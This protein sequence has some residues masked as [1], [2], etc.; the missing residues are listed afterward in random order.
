MTS[1]LIGSGEQPYI[2]ARR[3]WGAAFAALRRLMAN[4]DDTEQVF[5]IMDAL[6][7]DEEVR[8]FRK[9]TST[10]KGGAIAYRRV[11]LAERLMDRDWLNRFAPDSVGGVYRQFLDATGYSAQGLAEISKVG[12]SQVDAEHPYAW[13]GRRSRDVHDLWHVL[14]GYKADE[15]LGEAALVA[16]SFAQLG[17]WGWGA[18]ALATWFETLSAGWSNAQGKAIRE[19]YRLGKTAAWLMGEDYEQVLGERIVD[20]RRRLNIGTPE[21]YLAIPPE[22]RAASLGRQPAADRQV[23][24]LHGA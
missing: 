21:A 13:M 7:A 3:D 11:E 12:A 6:N 19:G 4:K 1:H 20:A 2:V 22:V 8:C 18:I 17:G 23:E 16:F 9:L 15:H 10:M 14:T 24:L 5:L